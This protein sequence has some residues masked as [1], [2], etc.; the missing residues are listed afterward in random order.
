MNP[1]D[2]F[3][4][5]RVDALREAFDASFAAPPATI[6]TARNRI[7]AFRIQGDAYAWPAG[8][9]LALVRGA[10]VAPLPDATPALAGLGQIGDHVAAVYRLVLLLG[11]P[12]A[13]EPEPWIVQCRRD[14]T[15]ALRLPGFSGFLE[16][17]PDAVKPPRQTATE[18]AHVCA[19]LRAGGSHWQLLDAGG[20]L[21][22]VRRLA[23]SPS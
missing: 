4:A 2:P 23:G 21:A 1:V 17:E 14:P 5:K 8:E 18:R 11:Y 10:A 13:A 9:S 12:T 16:A 7:L 15:V 22:A 19:I 3:D 20:I 6:G